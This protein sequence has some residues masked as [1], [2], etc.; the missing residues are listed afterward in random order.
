MIY[1]LLLRLFSPLFMQTCLYKPREHAHSIPQTYTDLADMLIAG[2]AD[3]Q[4]QTSQHAHSKLA[5][6]A[7]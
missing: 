1:T 7:I 3:M 5:V 4:I 2:L 6:V